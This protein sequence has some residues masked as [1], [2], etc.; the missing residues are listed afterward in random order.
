MKTVIKGAYYYD[1]DSDTILMPHYTGE[2]SIVDCNSFE[3]LEELENTYNEDYIKEA[4]ESPIEYEGKNYYSTEYSP[5]HV[6]DWE[7]LSDI[8]ELS[9]IEENFDF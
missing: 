5:Y 4:K 6:G 8:S 2:F 1:R 7:L 3:K 9:F